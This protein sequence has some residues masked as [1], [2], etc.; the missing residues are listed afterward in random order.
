MSTEGWTKYS[1]E[2]V[3]KALVKAGTI[4]GASKILK[5]ERKTIKNYMKKYPELVK[6]VQEARNILLDSAEDNLMKNVRKGHASSI[7]F[8]LKTLGKDRGYVERV[9]STGKDGNP[10]EM[11]HNFAGAKESLAEKF[12][13][14]PKTDDEE[15]EK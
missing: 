2:S 15:K 14:V 6:S 9:E 4:S 3:G 13:D 1:L 8:V 7:F 10:L 5:C 12:Q 11:N